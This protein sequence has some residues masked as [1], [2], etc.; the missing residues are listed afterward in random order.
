MPFV[1]LLLFALVCL[2]TSWPKWFDWPT[3]AG[4]GILVVTLIVASWLSAWLISETL[5]WQIT[6]H[7]EQRG[8]ILRRYSRC[9]RWHFYGLLVAYVGV[10]YILGWG[11][12]L[13]EWWV[14][15]VP[16]FLKSKD[17][18]PGFQIGLLA[19]FFIAL[20]ASWERFFGVEK[21][22]YESAHLGDMFLPKRSYL[23]MQFRH[24]FFL[25]IPPIL[26][27][28]VLQVLYL[29]F[30][31]EKSEWLAIAMIGIMAVAI[32]LMPLILRVFLG[33]TPLPP[34]NLRTRL[35]ATAR[36]LGFR[37]SNVLVWHTRHL[38]ANALVTG[39]V[40]WIRYV[41]LTD[42]LID[43]L[44]EEE[45][46]AVFGHEVGHVRYHHLFFYLAFFLTSFILLSI[47]WGQFRSF[48]GTDAVVTH[49]VEL[50]YFGETRDEIKETLR[51]FSSFVKLGVLGGYTMLCFGFIS[52]RCERQADLYGAGAV[53]TLVFISALEKV[54]ATNGIPRDRP[55]NWLLS[56]Q[57]PTIAQR[58]NFLLEM[59]GSPARV[60]QFHRSIFLLKWSF[61]L[62]LGFLVW[63]LQPQ[64]VWELLREF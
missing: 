17:N 63:W 44:T 51:L 22:A 53:S 28:S 13:V 56:W 55:G 58:V 23:L 12:V 43:D 59:D 2:Q 64:G 36:R 10:L 18:L 50:G 46:E 20:V 8:P 11:N 21:T 16:A 32:I 48:L 47:F 24:Q 54:A 49:L 34:G 7:P 62:A 40:P 61:F 30:D 27:M 52:R 41:V 60:P 14:E 4:C 1:F 57:H 25:V 35:E 42:R 38:I 9:R 39:F 45:I 6:R 31:D 37:F 5:S 33:L 15:W 26:L 29:F 3:P 19:P